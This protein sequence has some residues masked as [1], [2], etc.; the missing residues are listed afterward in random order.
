MM[1]QARVATAISKRLTGVS[2]RRAVQI[3]EGCVRESLSTLQ[4]AREAMGELVRRLD[5]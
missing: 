3:D 1:D 4:I 5:R 2:A